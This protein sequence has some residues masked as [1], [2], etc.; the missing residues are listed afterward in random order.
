MKVQTLRRQI[1]LNLLIS[2]LQGVT[3]WAEDDRSLHSPV[4]FQRDIW[5]VL[6]ANCQGCHQPAKPQG[7]YVMTSFELLVAGGESGSPAIVEGKS[8]E[9]YLVE[10]IALVDGEAKMP[11]DRPPLHESEVELIRR[12]I[13]QGALNDSTATASPQFDAEHPPT[14]SRPPVVTSLDHSPDG[15]L[16]AVAG[17][18]EV[19][20]H[21]A[22][23]SGPVARL[24]GLSPRIESVRF[25][26]DGSR[27][28]VAGGEPATAGEIQIWN[29]AEKLLERSISVTF[30]T[31][32]GAS[33]SPDGTLVAVGCADSTVR[34]FDVGTGQQTFYQG[35]HDDLVRDTVFSVQGDHLVSVGRD[36]TAKLME[37]KTERFIDNITSITPDALKGGI[38]S[39]TRHP[40]R[41]EIIFGGAD[42]IPKIYKMFRTKERKPGDDRNQLWELPPLAGRVFSVDI[43]VDA[44]RIA[45]GSSLNGKGM[46]RVF[47]M[48][49]APEIPEDIIG[50]LE[51]PTH[52]RSADNVTKLKG[53]F[54]Q[55]VKDLAEVTFDTGGIFCVSF[56]PDGSQLAAAGRDGT[57]RLI[58]AESGEVTKE[59]VPVELESNV[60]DAALEIKLPE[61]DPSSIGRLDGETLPDG[62]TITRLSIQPDTLQIQ[63]VYEQVQAIVSAELDTGDTIDVTRIADLQ[64]S[65][66]A[67]VVSPRGRVLPQ[68]DGDARL[69]AKLHGNSVE[70]DVH[71]SGQADRAVPDFIRD[72][73]P[74]LSRTGC[75]AGTCHGSQAGK[76]GFKL[77]LRGYDPL[78]DTRVLTDDLAAR[79]INLASP[80]QSLILLK[81]AA[82]VPHEG[83]QVLKAGS[84]YYAIVRDWIAHGAKLNPQTS[85]VAAIKVFPENPVVQ[86]IGGRQ[87]MRV[88]AFYLEGHQRDV[89]SEA[90]IES[91]NTDIAKPVVD[92]PGLIEVSRRGEAPLLVRY[93]GAYA[94]TT[95]TVMGDRQ[96]FVWQEPPA[97]GRIDELVVRKLYRT[98]TL[99]SS[100]CDDYDFVRRVYLDLTG[101]PPTPEQ[102][103]E[104][105]ENSSDSRWKRDLLVDYLI[106]SSDFIEHWTNK[107]CDLLQVNGKF[108]GREGATAMRSWVRDHVQNNTPYDD[109]SRAL[110]TGEGSNKQNPEVSY[111]KILRFPEDLVENTTH[112]F[113]AT[114]FNCNKCHDHPFER[115]TQDQYYELAAFFSRVG[116]KADPAGGDKTIGGTSVE[117]AKPFYEIVFE[118]PAGEVRHPRTGKEVPPSFPFECNFETADGSTR[119]EQLAAWITSPDNPYFARS[120]VNRLWGYLTGVGIIEPIDDIRAGNPP[121]NPEL[122]DWLTDEFLQ[123]G[124]NSQHI[125]RLI[126]KSRTYQAAVST[127][128]WNADDLINYSHAIPRRLPA[129]VL[130]DAIHN[131]TGVESQ[132][133]GVPKG[134]RAAALPDSE[135]KLPDGFLANFGRPARESACEC[136]RANDVQLGSVMALVS[137]P[138]LNDAISQPGNAIEVLVNGEEDDRRLVEKLF[139]RVLGRPASAQVVEGALEIVSQ[140][141]LEHRQL[142]E[143]LATLEEELRHVSQKRAVERQA[144][145]EQEKQKLGDLERE[146]TPKRKHAIEQARSELD[147]YNTKLP[148]LFATWLTAQQSATHWQLLEP[149]Q[150]NYEEDL[151]LHREADGSTYA[152]Q[153][154]GERQYEVTGVTE[155]QR[156]TGIRLEVLPDD[157]LPARG[158]GWAKDGNFVIT[159]FK[160]AHSVAEVPD[161]VRIRQWD[162]AGDSSPWEATNDCELIQQDGVLSVKRTGDA[163]GMAARVGV[164]AG[165]FLIEVIARVSETQ[166]LDL[167]WATPTNPDFSDKTKSQKVR[168]AGDGSSWR[169]Y[170]FFFSSDEELTGLKIDPDKHDRPLEFD[171]IT[172]VKSPP[173]EMLPLTLQNARADFSQEDY[174]VETAIDGKEENENNGWAISSQNGLRHVALFEFAQP[175]ISVAQQVL[176]VSLLQKHRS[177][178][179]TLGRFRLSLTNDPQPLNLGNPADIESLLVLSNQERTAEQRQQLFEYFR[180]QD[181]QFSELQKK[182]DVAGI[183]ISEYPEVVK[184][185]EKIKQLELPLPVDPRLVQLR[186]D[187]KLSQK[188]LANRRLIAAQ[189]ITW[190]LVNSPAFL[191]NR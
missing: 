33:W 166:S 62:V 114:R 128:R 177:N 15:T 57:V 113:L 167:R 92:Y 141:E 35:S 95:L 93:E 38:A 7:D 153:V 149:T 60:V 179:H 76:G 126:C 74:V 67:A 96:G 112:L 183:P 12:W 84:S 37:L 133:A 31:V 11:K 90:F 110:I 54:R 3:A 91:G 48:A 25:S 129:E 191:F 44:K 136:E 27:L 105:V 143:K 81:P 73:N 24:I 155:L 173:R 16:L 4:S 97:N 72:V 98:K 6:Q 64:I 46:V 181:L 102:I 2:L 42:G 71:V 186:S 123:S 120:Y 148:G 184:F 78:F 147:T 49:V 58:H 162:F 172:L 41:D 63:G 108:L 142:Q 156:I 146:L 117:P 17:F 1:F 19:V 139:L 68:E 169:R 55:G 176:K 174:T 75:N 23:G 161:A 61:I 36:M 87:Q 86:G 151:I 103:Q 189:D 175:V 101:L 104:F 65:G 26:P 118:K 21:N 77:S 89:T 163:P 164:P 127:N 158:P 152:D 5:P 125:L 187:V 29:V 79:R 115:W 159:E 56:H 168:I 150:F 66:D 85:K 109:F 106:G 45:A 122:L 34:V 39:V 182:L 28:A 50:I 40:L 53:H 8:A 145:V 70:A 135:I 30:D 52:K 43:S 20:L 170:Q 138:T 178:E 144:K 14:Y 190:G 119:R 116:L 132:F 134:L 130:L 131:V 10:Q 80:T 137:G 13:D 157:R 9:S 69:V 100:L 99:P 185:R 18:N 188:Q 165:Q 94:A 59:F 154:T 83:G 22:D 111:Y 140:V 51:Q 124:F 121:S 32:F 47:E 107:W 88:V 82:T 180:S 160:V 171:S